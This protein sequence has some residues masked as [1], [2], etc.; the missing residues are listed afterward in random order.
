M[1]GVLKLIQI[2]EELSVYPPLEN[3]NI[4]NKVF[5]ENKISG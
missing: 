5:V 3:I 4:G 1:T 2:E